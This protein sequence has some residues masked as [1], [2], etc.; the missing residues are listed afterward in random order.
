M[1]IK[2]ARDSRRLRSQDTKR[3]S[4]VKLKQNQTYKSEGEEIRGGEGRGGWR[5]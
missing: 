1:D 5:T 3:L 2:M 4:R